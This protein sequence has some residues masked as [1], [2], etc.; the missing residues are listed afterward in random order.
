M[1]IL[2]LVLGIVLLIVGAELLV[3]GASQL[4]FSFG[5][6]PLVVGLTVVAFGTSAPELAVSTKAAFEGQASIAIGN[7]VGSNIF[8][9]LLI[10]GLSA[11]ITP[12]VV[13]QQ[14][15]RFDV[16]LMI[17]VSFLTFFLARDGNIS[18]LDGAVLFTGIVLYTSALIYY[19]RKET[20]SQVSSSS[21]ESPS[22]KKTHWFL[23]LAL[24]GVG[25]FLLVLGSKFLV[26]SAVSI[27]QYLGVSELVI[28]LTIVAGGTSLP[29]VVTSVI[30]SL[31]G[32]RDIAV[33]NVVGSNIFNI[34]CVL[35]LSSLVSPAGIAVSSAVLAF[36]IPIMIAVAFVCLPIFFTDG[37]ISRWEGGL[38]FLY[39]ILYTAYLI[40]AAN[41]HSSLPLFN[42]GMLYFVV[43]LTVLT[44]FVMLFLAIQK[45]RK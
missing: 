38:L 29:E 16:P 44:L 23:D 24:I 8:N 7:V 28:A 9:I 39:Y 3:R 18:R 32:E 36:D 6:S 20:T 11:L 45:K 43:P 40:L 12:L 34:L 21:E 15:I 30:A 42:Q 33:G 25:L 22:P 27:A 37:H 13:S 19:S 4:A 1:V 26:N 10:L 31:R 14:L 35:G 2:L 41:K 5:I 17:V